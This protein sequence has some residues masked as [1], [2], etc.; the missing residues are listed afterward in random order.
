MKSVKGIV[1]HRTVSSTSRSAVLTTFKN[2]GLTGFH[3]VVDKDGSITQVN[4]FDNRANHVGAKK[5]KSG[6]SSYNSIGVEVVGNSLDGEGNP[7]MDWREVESWENLTSDQIEN[8]AQ[9]V[10]TLMDEIA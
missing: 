6:I 5:G 3:A 10:V 1:L 9:L 4:N 8:T 7:T 2:K